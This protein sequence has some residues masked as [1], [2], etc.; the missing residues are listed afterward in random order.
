MQG[1]DLKQGIDSGNLGPATQVL[2]PPCDD[3]C[4][5]N[6]TLLNLLAYKKK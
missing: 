4:G 1:E 6:S 2:L 5:P 3:F